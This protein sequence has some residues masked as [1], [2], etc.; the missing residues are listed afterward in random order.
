M[1]RIEIKPTLWVHCTTPE[2]VLALV[3]VLQKARKEEERERRKAELKQRREAKEN[4][5]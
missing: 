3:D 4:R 5:G 1:Y 2:E